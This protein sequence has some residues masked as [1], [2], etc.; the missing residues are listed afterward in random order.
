MS[1]PE[2]HGWT[3]AAGLAARVGVTASTVRRRAARGLYESRPNP[4][5]VGAI[6]RAA[7]PD[8]SSVSL[9]G[10]GGLFPVSPP[11]SAPARRLRPIDRTVLGVLPASVTGVATRLGLSPGSASRALTRLDRAGYA[12]PHESV[13]DGPKGGRPAIV[14]RAV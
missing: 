6:Y 8:P 14:W 10:G 4:F 3:T 1:A 13:C 5:G 12:R 2:L 11:R 9:D 7:P